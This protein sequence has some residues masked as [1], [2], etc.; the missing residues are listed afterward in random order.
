MSQSDSRLDHK[1]LLVAFSMPEK[2]D[3]YSL[4]SGKAL[5]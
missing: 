2:G 1:Y 3:R 4:G 5:I